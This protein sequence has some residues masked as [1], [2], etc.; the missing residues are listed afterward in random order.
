[1]QNVLSHFKRFRFLLLAMACT[2]LF[3]AA[4][5]YRA[6]IRTQLGQLIRK[7]A[8]GMGYATQSVVAVSTATPSLPP[9][10]Q[11][12][13]GELENQAALSQ[14]AVFDLRA[15]VQKV[16]ET[17]QAVQQELAVVH[18][19]Q[20]SASRTTQSNQNQA[21]SQTNNTNTSNNK[22]NINTAS[23][24]ELDALP[25]IGPSYAQRIIEYRNQQGDF[26]TIQDILNVPGIGE[27]IF[28]KIQTQITV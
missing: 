13:L 2:L 1:M 12:H 8:R 11:E 15:Q 5:T 6:P 17:L 3:S 20:Q 7:T 18:S 19:T 21:S 27:S 24:T 16:E 14:Q 22:V 4:Y 28:E 23:T 10:Y 26:R 9:Q 25:G